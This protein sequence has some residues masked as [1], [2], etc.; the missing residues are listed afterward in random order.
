M[1]AFI[2]ART[3]AP[4]RKFIYIIGMAPLFLPALVGALAWSMLASPTAGF[5]NVLPAD[6]GLRP[7]STSTASA[8]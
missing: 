1:L 8:G 7:Q 3:N 4:L 2:A 5:V 6:L